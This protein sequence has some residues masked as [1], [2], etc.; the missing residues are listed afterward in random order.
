MEKIKF[1]SALTLIGA[2]AFGLT[3]CSSS[4][5]AAGTGSNENGD[6]KYITVNLTSVGTAGAAGAKANPFT[7]AAGDT[8]TANGGNYENG[9]NGE[10]NVKSARFYFYTASGDPY[11]M[12]GTNV[13]WLEVKG[14]INNRV[15]NK[16][17]DNATETVENKTSAVLV[18][19]GVN[20][21]VPRYM[22][23]IVNPNDEAK[24]QLGNGTL[25]RGDLSNAEKR[26]ATTHTIGATDDDTQFVMSSSTYD[27]GGSTV[28][29]ALTDGHIYN[30]QDDAKTKPVDIYVERLDAKVRTSLNTTGNIT[31]K[32]IDY[33]TK[34]GNVVASTTEG[35]TKVSGYVYPVAKTDAGTQVYA[36]VK[37]WGVADEEA[38]ASLLKDWDD[39]HKTT[40]GNYSTANPLG[41]TWNDASLHRSYWEYTA[42]F[43]G[44]NT[45]VNHSFNDY[46]KNAFG[47][48][49]YTKPNTQSTVTGFAS[50]ARSAISTN[51]AKVVVVA[52][53][54]QKSGDE[55][56]PIEVG[57]YKGLQVIGEDNLK[58][59]VLKDLSAY[60]YAVT[61]DGGTTYKSLEAKNITFE[62]FENGRTYEIIPV[63]NVDGVTTLYTNA[64]H[65]ATT[66]V[67][68]LNT[69]LNS[70]TYR[71]EMRKSGDTYYYTPIRHLAPDVTNPIGD[72]SYPLGY[73]GVVRNH[74]YNVTINSLAGFGTPV[75]D[76]SYAF[77]PITPT[78]SA[79]YIA[80]RINVLSWR[81]VSQKSNIDGSEITQ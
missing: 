81:I 54:L 80:A 64:D 63:V 27:D 52:Q 71:A 22:A 7:R 43:Q 42:P 13:N 53:L 44:A 41:F 78:N 70:A 75:Y 33:Y 37:G 35:A 74:L 58:A 49:L 51:I 79:S 55:W 69:T 65:T 47:S 23:C 38:K 15:D 48:S 4:D 34:D 36:L 28:F 17:K 39:T 11:L 61:S 56:L 18:I 31:W 1:L 10:N 21:T 46:S 45:I 9:T 30:N 14:F 32:S 76:P 12:Q 72:T 24:T 3:A 57:K 16:N 67:S 77:D 50:A 29:T 2:A 19:N 68:E 66:T 73:Y 6:S 25:T 62:R 26:I 60:S 40:W 8:F 59:E 20:G 5:D